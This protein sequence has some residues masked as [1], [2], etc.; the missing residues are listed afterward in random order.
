METEK[1]VTVDDTLNNAYVSFRDLSSSTSEAGKNEILNFGQVDQKKASGSNTTHSS[2]SY[3]KRVYEWIT[4]CVGYLASCYKFVAKFCTSP[5]NF[6]QASNNSVNGRNNLVSSTV[7][8]NPSDIELKGVS[9]RPF[10]P[11]ENFFD[12]ENKKNRLFSWLSSK[13]V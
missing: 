8:S 4:G 1:S 11:E 10:D 3:A 9:I 13:K 2:K 12:P 5:S 7:D 6:K